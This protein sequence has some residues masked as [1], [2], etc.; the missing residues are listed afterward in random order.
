MLEMSQKSA[1]ILQSKTTIYQIR[2]SDHKAM[3]DGVTMVK[4]KDYGRMMS[5]SRNFNGQNPHS[6]P[7]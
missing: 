4:D 2:F 7:K 1:Q 6:K 3:K 5:R